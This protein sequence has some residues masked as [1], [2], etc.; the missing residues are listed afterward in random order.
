MP[1]SPKKPPKKKPIEERP[2]KYDKPI[3]KLFYGDK[4]LTGKLAREKL[5]GWQEAQ[6]S[7]QKLLTDAYGKKIIC[8]NNVSNR[9]LYLG[10]VTT[11]K[12]E[13]L[14]RRWQ[15][16]M[17][18]IIIGCTGLVLNGQHR[19]IAFVLAI[20]EWELHPEL[21]KQYW[22]TEPV[23][24]T[25]IGFGANESDDVV[26]TLDTCKPRSLADVI[27]RSPYFAD[28]NNSE[29]KAAARIT[30]YGVRLLWSRTGVANAFA[31]RRTHSESLDFIARHD[32]ILECV[33]HIHAENGSEKQLGE[34]ISPGY[35]AALLYLMASS[36]T[37]PTEYRNSDNPNEG[38]LDWDNWDKACD[39]WVYLASG[40]EQL[41]AV[42]KALGKMI[43]D[44]GG[45]VDEQCAILVKAWLAYA[46]DKP[47]DA[48]TLKL[49]YHTE[50]DIRS[51]TDFPSAGG[52]DLGD[53]DSLDSPGN[54][55][56]AVGDPTPDEI[57]A[58]SAEVRGKKSKAK[59]TPSTTQK[60]H[61]RLAGHVSETGTVSP[62]PK[63]RKKQRRDPSDFMGRLV[64]VSDDNREDWRGKVIE[65]IGKNAKVEVGQGHQGAGSVRAVTVDRLSDKQRA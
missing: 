26:N 29:R 23:L 51:L 54:N 42:S 47:I 12:Q 20:Q 63:K 11:L 2:V 48:K 56:P 44:D 13:I 65:V 41:S 64:W 16:N 38:M 62:I 21:W 52:I 46:A 22:P 57:K 45:S 8:H 14:R 59:P 40:N 50:D 43:N 19:L 53:P 6:D 17:E 10:V 34:F 31:I 30:D 15:R 5:L 49:N 24:E 61:E 36:S 3:V 32:R 33:K 35:A 18:N 60:T 58:R 7:E 55:E 39:F 28:M 4:A 27:Y 25:S 37:D 9:P 1:K